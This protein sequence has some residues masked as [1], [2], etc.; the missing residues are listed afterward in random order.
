MTTA[1]VQKASRKKTTKRLKDVN[2]PKAPLTP[3]LQFGNEQRKID[4]KI[5]SLPV[6]EQGKMLSEMWKNLAEDVKEKM[7][8]N[9][10]E[11]RKKYKKEFEEY[12]NTDS[13]K[14][15][16]EQKAELVKNMSMPDIASTVA[17]K[18]KSMTSEEKKI[19][20]DAADKINNEIKEKENV[21][22]EEMEDD[23]A[24]TSEENSDN[25]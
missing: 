8:S 9:Y 12:K 10:A 18:W 24:E 17:K 4:P 22:S 21:K 2:A 16:A 23:E 11:Q 7:K 14:E 5:N 13:Y 3:Y 20:Q 15:W 19:Y 25:E 1:K 6:G